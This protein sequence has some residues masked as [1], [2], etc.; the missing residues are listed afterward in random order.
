[1]DISEGGQPVNKFFNLHNVWN[2]GNSKNKA[3]KDKT[4]Y[5]TLNW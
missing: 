1:M 4:R 2:R 3:E 5:T